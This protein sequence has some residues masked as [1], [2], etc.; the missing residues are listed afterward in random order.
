MKSITWYDGAML[1]L[2]VL[3]SSECYIAIDHNRAAFES[4]H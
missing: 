1:D 2:H 4:D 3:S